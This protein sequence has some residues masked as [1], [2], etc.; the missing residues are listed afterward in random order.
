V[1]RNVKMFEHLPYSPDL[2]PADFFLF[3]KVKKEL[4]GLTLMRETFK[5]KW[6]GAVRTLSAADFAKAFQ[7]WF[8]LCKKCIAINGSYVEKT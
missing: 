1:A 8:H 7:Q 2:A 5:K 4:G 6:K 3:P